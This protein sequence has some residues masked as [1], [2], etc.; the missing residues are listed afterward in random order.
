MRI[1][2][3]AGADVVDGTATPGW[4]AQAVLGEGADRFHGGPASDQVNAGT[5]QPTRASTDTDADVVSTGGGIDAVTSGGGTSTNPDVIDLG[6]GNDIVYWQGRAAGPVGRVA[7]GGGLDQLATSVAGG[8]LMIDNATGRASYDGADLVA[9]SGL[10][11]F[12]LRRVG[13]TPTALRF[14]GGAG[15]DVVSLTGRDDPARPGVLALD[16][17]GGDDLFSTDAPGA[18]GST[19]A[20]GPGR[21]HLTI[22]SRERRLALDLRTARLDVGG[23]VSPATGFEG[24]HLLARTVSLRGTN[25][26]DSLRTTGCRQT[27]RGRAGRDVLGSDRS[28][29]RGLRFDCTSRAHVLGGRGRDRLRGSKGPDRLLGGAGRD[30]AEGRGGK[31]LCRAE[32]TRSCERR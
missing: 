7:A 6:G 27:I 28:E 15:K 20:G 5:G 3:A 26:P 9:L 16:L 24:A 10:E 32:R 2:T 4:G 18:P 31:D 17:G 25:G 23:V 29:L 13:P 21:D 14:L 19:Y 12:H 22:G 8:S 30:R 11:V 1:D